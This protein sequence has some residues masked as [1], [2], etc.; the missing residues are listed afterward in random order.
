[1]ESAFLLTTGKAQ[2]P[3]RDELMKWKVMSDPQEVVFCGECKIGSFQEAFL[4]HYP[5]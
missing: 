4:A 5:H 3:F 2:I 1:M